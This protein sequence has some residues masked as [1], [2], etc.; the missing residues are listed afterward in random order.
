MFLRR[1]GGGGREEEGSQ[2][3]HYRAEAAREWAGPTRVVAGHAGGAAEHLPAQG[4][5]LPP[6]VH[7]D[8]LQRLRPVQLVQDDWS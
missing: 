5:V 7:E 8:P 4:A 6:V 1:G 3:R 2:F